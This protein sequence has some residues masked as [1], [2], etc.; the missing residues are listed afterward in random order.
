MA[1]LLPAPLPYALDT[2]VFPFPAL[3]TLA[4]RATLGASRETVLACLL[5]ARLATAVLPPY[6]LTAEQRQRRADAAAAWL[7]ALALPDA[8]RPPLRALVEATGSRSPSEIG[9]ALLAMRQAV[10]PVLDGPSAAEL[11]ALAERLTA[12]PPAVTA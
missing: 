5:A 6:R 2:P 11:L 12:S 4:A 8:V 7:D 1:V 10:A 9:A 3:T